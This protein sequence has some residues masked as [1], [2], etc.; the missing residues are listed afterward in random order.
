MA[1][2]EKRTETTAEIAAI[3][4]YLAKLEEGNVIPHEIA[5]E[6]DGEFLLPNRPRRPVRSAAWCPWDAMPE[7]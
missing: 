2:E 3:L 5:L 7:D 1:R 6:Y 4:R